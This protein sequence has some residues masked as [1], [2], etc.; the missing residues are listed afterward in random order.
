MP[1]WFEI[2]K[3]KLT[4]EQKRNTKL[5][6]EQIKE[7][8]ELRKKGLGYKRI[9]SKFKVHKNVIRYYCDEEYRKK[10]IERLKRY[11]DNNYTKEK[12][13]EAI[14]RTRRYKAKI[15]GLKKQKK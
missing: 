3:V 9:A 1:Y 5:T 6:E 11:R 7:I 15:F 2:E 8:K 14:K 12:H 10:Q 4:R 13:R